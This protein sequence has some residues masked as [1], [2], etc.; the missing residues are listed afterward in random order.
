MRKRIERD[1]K[2]EEPHLNLT[3]EQYNNQIALDI[4][5]GTLFLPVTITMTPAALHAGEDSFC[6]IIISL[7]HLC[8]VSG[9]NYPRLSELGDISASVAG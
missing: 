6:R 9:S 5:I 8:F 7:S 3:C 4:Y 2:L 1:V